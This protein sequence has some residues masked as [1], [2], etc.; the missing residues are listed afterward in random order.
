MHLTLICHGATAATRRAA[1]PANEP[2]EANSVR[3][4]KAAGHRLAH[5]D[6]A[7]TSPALCARQTAE[8]L[9]LEAKV[10]TALR[11]CDYGRWTGLAFKNVA[12]SEPDAAARW[13]SDLSAAPHGGETLADLCQRASAWIDETLAGRGH[14]VAV[15]HAS[16]IRAA[17]VHVLEAP[18]TAF[19]RIDIEPLSAVTLTGTS[20]VRKLRFQPSR[21]QTP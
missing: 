16:V 12:A 20:R 3:D 2:L 13:L 15:T 19:W 10:H 6:Q 5:V 9:A 8:A 17:V 14:V 1:F 21:I 11:E 18:A 4:A 7:W